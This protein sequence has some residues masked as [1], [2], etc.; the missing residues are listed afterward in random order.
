MEIDQGAKALLQSDKIGI[1]RASIRTMRSY[2]EELRNEE[3]GDPKQESIV[4]LIERYWKTYYKLPVRA[5][6][7]ICRLERAMGVNCSA[8]ANRT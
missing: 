2:E 6:E 4:L 1:A 8:G 3:S 7:W 5:Q